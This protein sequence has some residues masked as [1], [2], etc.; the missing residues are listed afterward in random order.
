[1][2]YGFQDSNISLQEKNL[3]N[4]LV[5]LYIDITPGLEIIREEFWNK[6]MFNM[7]V[8]LGL[9]PCLDCVQI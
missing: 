7:H 3:D 8:K 2:P 6:E 4:S 5:I 9:P 1:M